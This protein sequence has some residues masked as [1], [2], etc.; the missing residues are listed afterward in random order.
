MSHIRYVAYGS[1]LHPARLAERTPS[2]CLLGTAFL[3]E[4]SL[5]FHKRSD[6]DGSGKCSI[7]ENGD[8]IHIAIYEIALADKLTL[9]RIEGRGVGYDEILVNVPEFGICRTYTARQSHIDDE[10][11]P[12][13]W[14]K[15]M[16]I[17]GCDLHDF[18][19]EYRS[20]IAAVEALPDADSKRSRPEWRI[21]NRLRYGGG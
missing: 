2:A 13:D 9:D 16:V 3:P 15:E 20:R 12:F 4:W 17:L 6:R 18:P 7:Q 14:Y 10:L 21:V 5:H 19:R 1:N 11:A 8:G